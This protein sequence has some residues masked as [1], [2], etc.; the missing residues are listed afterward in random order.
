MRWKYRFRIQILVKDAR[1][2]VSF[3]LFEPDATIIIKRNAS[4]IKERLEKVTYLHLFFHFDFFGNISH[5]ISLISLLF[6]Q[7]IDCFDYPFEIEE[8]FLG[9]TFLF[10]VDVAQNNILKVWQSFTVVKLTND[11]SIIADFT[12][13]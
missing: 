8:A 5:N 1:A 12:T 11:E 4:Q 6:C 3:V 9:K 13:L 7:E 10:K 2:N